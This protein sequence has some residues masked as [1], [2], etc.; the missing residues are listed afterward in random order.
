MDVQF[1]IG[2]AVVAIATALLK[3]PQ[4][5]HDAGVPHPKEHVQPLASIATAG[6]VLAASSPAYA[7]AWKEFGSAGPYAGAAFAGFAALLSMAT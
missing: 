5:L 1:I 2:S 7:S 3:N 4:W 6:M